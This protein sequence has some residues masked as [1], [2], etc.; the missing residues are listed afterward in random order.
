MTHYQFSM[1]IANNLH[2]GGG[3]YLKPDLD[4]HKGYRF[5]LETY[6]TCEMNELNV[7]V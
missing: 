3:C 2:S 7:E 1:G 4:Q 5:K 6:K